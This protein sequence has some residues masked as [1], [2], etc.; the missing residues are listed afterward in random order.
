MPKP[1]WDDWIGGMA[2]VVI[3]VATPWVV[4]ALGGPV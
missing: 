3:V 4:W 1:Q 2:L